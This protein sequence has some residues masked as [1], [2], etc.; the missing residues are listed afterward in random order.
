MQNTSQGGQLG[1]VVVAILRLAGEVL[2][3]TLDDALDEPL[4]RHQ[5]HVLRPRPLLH[6]WRTGVVRHHHVVPAGVGKLWGRKG[7]GV[8]ECLRPAVLSARCIS[9]GGAAL[10]PPPGLIKDTE[11]LFPLKEARSRQ[12]VLIQSG[13]FRKNLDCSKKYMGYIE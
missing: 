13:P 7:G 8:G 6:L 5:W 3:L 4:R 1:G 11:S 2:A 9:N 12:K 10:H